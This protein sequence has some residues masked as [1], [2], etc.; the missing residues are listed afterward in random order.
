MSARNR[1]EYKNAFEMIEMLRIKEKK[2]Q[3]FRAVKSY[4]DFKAREAGIPLFGEFEITPLCNFDCKM[5]YVHLDTEQL[6]NQSILSVETWK[7]LM[8]QAWE[9]GMVSVNLTGG[10]CLAYPGFEELFVYL[11]SLGCEVAVLTN[12]YLL[13]EKKIRFFKIHMPSRIHIT[14]YGWNE[15]VYERVTGKRAFHTVVKNIKRAKEENLPISISITP[16]RYLGDDLF[17]TIRIA[18]KLCDNVVIN[19]CI[20]TPREETGRSEQQDDIDIGLYIR[21]YKYL[22]QLKGNE[23]TGLKTNNLPPSGG[24]RHDT[25]KRGLRCGGGRSGFA[26]DWKGV[27]M[28]CFDMR[29]IRGY[30]LKDGFANAWSQIN[31]KANNWPRV[32]ECEGCVYDGVCNNCAANILRLT[33]PGQLPTELCEQTKELVRNGIKHVPECEL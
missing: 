19:P 28:P 8:F 7:S 23:I 27:L 1:N 12:G 10:E 25:S 29:A 14:L 24:S 5:C 4:L 26:I 22:Y 16:N 21:A 33:A 6:N 2:V 31:Y 30:P 11:H 20:S 3:E 17:E 32:S 15:D 9:A 13:D 18:K